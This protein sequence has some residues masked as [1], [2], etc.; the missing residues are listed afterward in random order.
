MDL[1]D[2]SLAWLPTRWRRE[3]IL[4]LYENASFK[5]EE[6]VFL[7]NCISDK[8]LHFD[9]FPSD[10]LSAY[11]SATCDIV[12]IILAFFFLPMDGGQF[13]PIKARCLSAKLLNF[14]D[15]PTVSLSHLT[16]LS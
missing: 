14:D 13:L 11:S 16:S 1:L 6:T 15:Y 5:G 12:T 9:E 4:C 3:A 10:H 8:L 7:R 2:T